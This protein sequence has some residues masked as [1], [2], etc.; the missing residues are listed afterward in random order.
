M[1]QYPAEFIIVVD[2]IDQSCMNH[3]VA[4]GQGKSIDL[5]IAHDMKFDLV[6]LEPIAFT[7]GSNQTINPIIFFS[8]FN[9][10]LFH[11]SPY[12]IPQFLL[13]GICHFFNAKKLHPV[14]TAD[15]Q[16]NTCSQ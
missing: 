4:V 13:K 10:L 12:H 7:N 11:S 2:G 1:G 14:Y 8:L 5:T 3:H 15:E 6:S 16:I 9:S